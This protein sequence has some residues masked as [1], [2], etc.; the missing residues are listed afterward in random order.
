VDA[1]EHR[2]VLAQ[3]V[4]KRDDDGARVGRRALRRGEIR[5]AEVDESAGVVGRERGPID[6]DLAVLRRAD[7][8]GRERAAPRAPGQLLEAQLRVVVAPAATGFRPGDRQCFVGR[9]CLAAAGGIDGAAAAR[10]VARE[11]CDRVLEDLLGRR[12]YRC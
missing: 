1:G 2:A 11:R 6:G 8:R 10:S 12:R 3:G 5:R 9:E 7:R 4:G